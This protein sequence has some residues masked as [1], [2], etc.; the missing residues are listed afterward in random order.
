M[1]FQS[2]L[3][4]LILASLLSCTA[5]PLNDNNTEPKQT[6]KKEAGGTSDKSDKNSDSKTNDSGKNS[7]VPAKNNKNSGSNGDSDCANSDKF[8]FDSEDDSGK[9]SDEPAKNNKNSDSN[10]DSDCGKSDKSGEDK[11]NDKSDKC[12]FDSEDDSGKNSN[13]PDKNNKNSDSNDDSDCGKSDKS[14]EDKDNDKSDKSDKD[15]DKD[16]EEEKDEPPKI[17]NFSLPISQQPG[18]FI[19]FGQNIIEKGQ[20]QVFLFGDY[21]QTRNG[22]RS[23]LFPSIL[24]GITDEFS[25]FFNFPVSPGNKQDHDHSSGLEDWFIQLEYAFYVDSTKCDVTQATIVGSLLFPTGSTRKVPPTGFGSPSLFFGLTYN[26]TGIYC[27]SFISPGVIVTSLYHD[28]RFG[29]Q[30]LYEGGLG[31]C[32]WTPPG[33]IFAWMIELDGL[34]AERNLIEG[35]IDPNSGGHLVYLTPSLWISSEKLTLQLGIGFPIYQ[36]LFGDQLRQ[37]YTL[38]FNI[39]WT[40]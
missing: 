2:Y 1:N 3:H 18:P 26:R 24:Y 29:N 11:D 5:S 20:T 15:K 30:Y 6:Y 21:I 19:S 23:D 40:F 27:F 39:G 31:R 32:F 22:Y 16:K 28:T 14:G 9:N 17:G 4:A 25:V 34:Y 36:D 35:A 13:E 33:W 10:N 37:Y 12:D 8:D 7:D 38:D